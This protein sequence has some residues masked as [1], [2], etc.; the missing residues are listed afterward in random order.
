MSVSPFATGLSMTT[1][2]LQGIA[3]KTKEAHIS[4]IEF[5]EL[6]KHILQGPKYVL[7]IICTIHR[8][9]T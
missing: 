8:K 3:R 4:L 1:T 7:F 2:I 5:Y 9:S 6:T